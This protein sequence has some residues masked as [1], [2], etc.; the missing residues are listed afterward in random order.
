[1]NKNFWQKKKVLVAGAAGFIGSHVVDSLVERRAIV[2]AGV[3]PKI[4][5]EK[6]KQ[7]LKQS[8]PKITIKKGDLLNF[9]DC[10][11]LTK[12]Q[13]IVLNFAAL[14][15]GAVFKLK[16]PSLIFRTNTQIVLNMLEASQFN[17]IDRFLLISSI[18]VYPDKTPSPIKEE[19]EIIEDFREGIDGYVW[20]K[21][22]SEITARIY[23]QDD[24]LK[25][26]IARPGNV[27]GPRDSLDKEKIRAIPAFV[28]QS[29]KGKDISIWGDGSPKR[30]F[31]YIE[32]L[33]VGLLD[34]LEKYPVGDPVNLASTNYISIKNLASL[35][36]DLTKSKSRLIFEKAPRLKA[37]DKI[38]STEKAQKVIEFKERMSL[39]E[40]L[41]KTINYF[42]RR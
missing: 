22:I 42:S 9:K 21:R 6:I 7:N 31:L 41:K 5:Q 2:T 32:D 1:M 15:G 37:K 35:I 30:S 13:D 24:G 16:Y 4:T 38:I 18:A 20:A 36:I 34:L 3:Y 39:E 25:I 27:Y 23:H 40:G 11:K 10:L 33:A 28:T 14:D 12:G 8:L 26:A 29:L 19:D 17:K